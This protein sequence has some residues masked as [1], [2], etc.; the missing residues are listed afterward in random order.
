[1]TAREIKDEAFAI[2]GESSEFKAICLISEARHILSLE[3]RGYV[4]APITTWD[5]DL[6][7]FSRDDYVREME[8]FAFHQNRERISN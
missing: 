2:L 4:R 5:D 7:V 3:L 8:M 6:G 1:V